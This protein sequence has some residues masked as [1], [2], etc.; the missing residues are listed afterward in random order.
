MDAIRE[1][2]EFNG[3]V[4][5]EP[6]GFIKILE[7]VFGICAFATTSSFSSFL[8]ILFTCKDKGMAQKAKEIHFSYPFALDTIHIP[9]DP[10]NETSP[11]IPLGGPYT[12]SAEFFVAIGVLT[13]LYCLAALL[14]YLF[15]DK[16]YRARDMVAQT[17]FVVTVFFAFMWLVCASAWAHGVNG[18]KH[19]TDP[20]VVSERLT[21]TKLTEKFPSCNSCL[22]GQS[23][24]YANLN[25]SVLLGFLNFFIWCGNVWFLWKETAWYRARYPAEGGQPMGSAS[26]PLPASN[27]DRI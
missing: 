18:V 10:C 15:L 1:G 23:P 11:V 24:N 16:L 5:K 2:M 8:T 27:M 20:A 3:R 6:R 14:L 25:I 12:S 19:C 22:P 4:W 21:S 26:G 9:R 17:D 7:L 13:F